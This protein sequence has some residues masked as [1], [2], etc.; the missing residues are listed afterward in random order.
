MVTDGASRVVFGG[1]RVVNRVV[2]SLA[3][4]WI[5]GSVGIVVERAV[6]G[7]KEGG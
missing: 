2:R 3:S 4:D 6:D 1:E 7:V 5:V